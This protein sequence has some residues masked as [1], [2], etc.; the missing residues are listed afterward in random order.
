[1]FVSDGV[2][3]DKFP[4]LIGDTVVTSL[5]EQLDVLDGVDGQTRV[6]VPQKHIEPVLG[7]D[8]SSCVLFVPNTNFTKVLHRKIPAPILETL[9]EV[10]NG[11][12]PV[13]RWNNSYGVPTYI[14]R[15]EV[16]PEGLLNWQPFELIA[17]LPAGDT[18]GV[19]LSYVDESITLRND[20][21][22]VLYYVSNSNGDSNVVKFI[23]HEGF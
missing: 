18:P 3:D 5:A 7:R 17:R 20:L 9:A 19:S 11:G 2:P 13:L 22:G 21:W 23:G 10:T 14:F 1:M 8:Y 4:K 12:H 16:S 15:T 6:I